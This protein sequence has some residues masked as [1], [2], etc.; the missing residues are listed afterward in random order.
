MSSPSNHPIHLSKISLAS[1]K[2]KTAG[3]SVPSLSFRFNSASDD[4]TEVTEEGKKG[5]NLY[6]LLCRNPLT[7]LYKIDFFF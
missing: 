5:Q 6:E 2:G 7:N 1:L 3:Q 4:I